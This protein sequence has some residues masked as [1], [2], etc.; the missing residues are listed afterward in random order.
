MTYIYVDILHSL[1]V[2]ELRHRVKELSQV[3]LLHS[4]RLIFIEGL[5]ND[6]GVKGHVIKSFNLL[7][8]LDNYCIVVLHKSNIGLDKTH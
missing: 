5:L 8:D 3:Y 2:F 6:L 1:G 4:T 7:K